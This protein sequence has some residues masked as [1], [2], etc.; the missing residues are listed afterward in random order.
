MKMPGSLRAAALF[1]V[2]LLAACGSGSPASQP[3]TQIPV[4]P[5]ALAATTAPTVGST[6]S[7]VAPSEAA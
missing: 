2:V 3:Q 5:T 1:V 4:E 6:T 7:E